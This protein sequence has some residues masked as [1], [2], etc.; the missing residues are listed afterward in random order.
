MAKEPR[1]VAE[2]GRPETPGETAAR[3]AASSAAYRSSKTVRNLV[4]ALLV[5]LGIV[6]VIILGV[7]RG[8]VPTTEIDVAET[9]QRIE[10]GGDSGLIVPELPDTW[11]V[12][13]AVVESD[14][15]VRAW[16]IIY[17]PESGQGYLRV[18]QGFEADDA[19]ASRV[20]RGAETE[21]TVTIDGITWDRYD[22][23]GAGETGNITQGFATQAGPDTI[24]IYGD[25]DDGSLVVAAESVADQ[26]RQLQEES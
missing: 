10:S 12:N 18:E 20:L 22:V 13:S 21:D 25:T 17:V 24:L 8:E 19:W 26:I 7:P 1:V 5:T 16:T 11:R 14:D 2:L 9:A 6:A 4:V 15:A 3:K 23:S